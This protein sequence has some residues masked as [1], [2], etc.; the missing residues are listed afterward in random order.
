M[1]GL[2]NIENNDNNC[3]LWCHVRH[4]NLVERNP[5]R[6]AVKDRELVNKF[7]YRGINFPISKKDSCRIEMLNKIVLMCF[8]MTIN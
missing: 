2:I 3:F 8:F 7:D 5:Q 1:K 6:I 4:L